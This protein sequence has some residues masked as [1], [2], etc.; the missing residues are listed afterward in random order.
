MPMLLTMAALAVAPTAVAR[1]QGSLAPPSP[2]GRTVTPVFEGWYRN[3]DGSYSLS[4]GYYNRN[5]VEQME[6]PVGSD[7]F[8][9]PGAANQGQP[10]SFAPRRHF[11]VFAVVVPADFGTKQIVWT[12]KDRGQTFA[13]AGSLRPDWEIDAIE[14]EASSENTPPALRFTPAGPEGRGPLGVTTAPLRTRVG[15]P[16]ALSVAASDDAKTKAPVDLTW[17][18]HQGPGDVSFAPSTNRLAPTGG[19]ATTTATFNRAGEYLIRVRANDLSAMT[20]GHAQCCWTNGFIPVTVI[21]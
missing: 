17:F 6:V 20:A 21:P 8:V 4:F 5:T 7:N 15:V 12:V 10:S 1:A 2:S 11:G 16:L 9:A 14:G 13:I 18:K 19:A 3:K